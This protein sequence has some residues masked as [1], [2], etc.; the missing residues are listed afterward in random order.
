MR[1][2]MALGGNALQR[3]GEPAEPGVLARN[4]SRAADAVAAIA[5]RHEVVVTHGN[6]PQVGM[7]ALAADVQGRNTALDLLV[8]ESEG[9]IGYLIERELA[10]LLPG[11]EIAT[12]L[13]QVEVDPA[14]PAFA[15][16]TKPIGPVYGEAEARR[17]A[18]ERSW[19]IMRDGDH[20]RR[21]VASPEPRRLREL[22]A[23]RV[24]LGGGL[25][26]ICS[27]GGGIPVVAGADGRLRGIEAV[28]DKDRTAA[29]L[30]EGLEADAL[31]LLTDVAAV[32]T[33]WGDPAAR[34][35]AA[36]SPAALGAF[37]FAPGSMGPKV[38]AACRFVSRT[39]GFAG[40]GAL[41]DAPAILKG[42]A[43]TI[44]RQMQDPIRYHG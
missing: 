27:G 42:A 18:A 15:A 16:P 20:F 24:L 22:N 14:D 6:G 9:Q 17:L 26:V 31:L 4:L 36:A 1:V 11:R 2:V 44:I 30:A 25:V 37:R 40:I 8:A 35:I 21:A 10:A 7:L 29:L 5:R 38:E 32:M 28:I 41:G 33:H 43:G 34:A 19:T 3:R 12:L 39:G 23:V 13:T